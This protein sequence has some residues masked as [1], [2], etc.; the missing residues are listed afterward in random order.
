[1][2]RL[3]IQIPCFNEALTLPETLA[4]LPRH[5]DGVSSIEV[6]LI[7]DGSTDATS[8]VGR[9][10]GVHHIVRHT[11]NQGLGR[12]FRTGLDYALQLGADI[13]V[14]VDADGQ[15]CGKDIARLIAPLLSG[16]ADIVI[17]DRQPTRNPE[18]SLLKRALQGIGSRVVIALSGI[19]TPD[20]VS[21]FRALSREAALRLNILSKFSYT[22]EM[23]IQAANKQLRV[24]SIPVSVNSARR[25]SRLFRSLPHFVSRQLITMLRMYTM[26]QP[27]RLFFSAGAL[28]SLLG[29]LPVLR[30]LLQYLAGDGSGHIQSLLLGGVLM[31]MGFVL[32]VAGLLSDLISQNRQIQEL[33]LEKVRR[34]EL[35]GQQPWKAD[36]QR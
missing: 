19:E 3:V 31:T 16:D 35:A 14:N 36:D 23:I 8:A 24:V 33:T 32:F 29:A 7:D 34:L 9:Q 21:G 15:Y 20:A 11:H 30:F 27:M 13:V 12:A 17:G 22:V 25:P 26:Y 6:L 5:V 28:L 4:D 1:M 10:H 2:T 18:F